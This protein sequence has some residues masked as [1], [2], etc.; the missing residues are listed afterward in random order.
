MTA[1]TRAINTGVDFTSAL[2]LGLAHAPRELTWRTLTTGRPAALAV[3]PLTSAV[4]SAFARLVG[5]E[6][7]VAFASTLHASNDL[8][9]SLCRP[10]TLIV[11]DAALYPITRWGIERAERHGARAVAFAH[12]SPTAL[13][14]V[15]AGARGTDDAPPWVVTDGVCAGCGCRAPVETYA[16]VVRRR[17]GLLIVDDAQAVGLYGAATTCAEPYGRGGGGSLARAGIAGHPHCVLVASLAKAFG[18]P[19]ALV[20]GPAEWVARLRDVSETLLHCSPPSAPALAAAARALSLGPAAERLRRR[21][22]ARVMRFRNMLQARGL[23]VRGGAAPLQRIPMRDATS[24]ARICE[25]LR[26]RGVHALARRAHCTGEL[27]V[28]FLLTVNH[29][30]A[31]IDQAANALVEVGAA[32]SVPRSPSSWIRQTGTTHVNA[33]DLEVRP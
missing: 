7:A 11:H 5:C 1:R 4:E 25:R 27:S 13:E 12:L 30:D 21:L 17:G 33:P 9:G 2:V 22:L 18:A 19:L 15:L 16:E 29:T 23:P 8:F 24:A 6:R 32:A 14:R 20:A 28:S 10:G 3:D 26:R 31:Q